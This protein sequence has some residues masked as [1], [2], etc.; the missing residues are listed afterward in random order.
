[1]TL[2]PLDA[3]TQRGLRITAIEPSS[4]ASEIKLLPSDVIAAING[5]DL[6]TFPFT[7][8]LQQL[9]SLLSPPNLAVL[10]VLRNLPQ[11]DSS[12][13]VDFLVSLDRFPDQSFGFT[14]GP[15]LLPWAPK[16][17]KSF[18]SSDE[19]DGSA[20]AYSPAGLPIVKVDRCTQARYNGLRY[21]DVVVEV[22][23]EALGG[24]LGVLSCAD[25]V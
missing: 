3:V 25:V 20:F 7:A 17:K 9:S 19:W 2:A 22:N 15:I 1:M 11:V 14:P 6:I 5:C 24:E 18:F 21:G 23:G 10:A 13:V 8:A 4:F 16:K 12:S